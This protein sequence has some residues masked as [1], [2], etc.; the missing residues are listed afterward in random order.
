MQKKG[1]K[2]CS[3]EKRA[4]SIGKLLNSLESNRA[5]LKIK[6]DPNIVQVWRQC[7][8]IFSSRVPVRAQEGRYVHLGLS[9]RLQQCGLEANLR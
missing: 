7:F 1:E 4:S 9:W 5:R 6:V 3:V 2:L 8:S